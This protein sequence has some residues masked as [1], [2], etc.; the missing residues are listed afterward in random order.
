MISIF[1]AAAWFATNPERYSKHAMTTPIMATVP[2]VM[3]TASA[4]DT[5]R[6]VVKLMLQD[7]PENRLVHWQTHSACSEPSP[8]FTT[9]LLVERETPN[10]TP[11][12]ASFES[13]P[14]QSA[15]RSTL[16]TC[17]SSSQ[18]QTCVPAIKDAAGTQL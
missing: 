15:G 12:Q 13:Q 14:E 10:L 9:R 7:S 4:G 1:R 6:R 18:R 16:Q 8:F 2:N 3:P 5:G 11:P 17:D